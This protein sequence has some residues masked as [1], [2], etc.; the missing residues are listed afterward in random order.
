MTNQTRAQG[1]ATNLHCRRRVW[2]WVQRA[3]GP[4]VLA[5]ALSACQGANVDPTLHNFDTL[6]FTL[7]SS[8]HLA[9][10]VGEGIPEAVR[11]RVT[12]ETGRPVPDIAVSFQLVASDGQVSPS[13][14][15]SD[16]Q[17]IVTTNWIL[18]QRAGV[19][20][21]EITA[22]DNRLSRRLSKRVVRAQALPGVPD[23][24]QLSPSE[25]ALE[26]GGTQTLELRV[27][28][29]FGNDVPDPE[30]EWSVAD[31]AVVTVDGGGTL[32]G[33]GEGVSSVGASVTTFGS[34]RIDAEAT[35]SVT[36]VAEPVDE[37]TT[38]VH[39]NPSSVTLS[40]VGITQQLGITVETAEPTLVASTGGIGLAAEE[41]P[42]PE[43]SSLDDGV[44]SVSSDGTVTSTGT[45]ST[46]VL[47]QMGTASDTA[48]VTVT[49]ESTESEPETESDPEPEPEPE[50]PGAVTDLA[51]LG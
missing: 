9:G 38:V 46:K 2:S 15:R 13:V 1:R 50:A 29:E 14:G 31:Q 33:I 5:L 30:V 40:G 34:E 21:L 36:A 45:G 17:G 43:W 41:E 10:T 32:T 12:D 11:L 18:G 8:D 7:L 39:I 25:V 47:V 28:D 44:A 51:Y 4:M 26:V 35:A 24:V 19:H 23:T 37:P 16:T 20:E 48:D 27:V 42:S 22:S 49:E 6:E 3:T